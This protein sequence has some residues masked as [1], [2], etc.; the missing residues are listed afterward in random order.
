MLK[1]RELGLLT[2]ELET[3][4]LDPEIYRYQTKYGISVVYFMFDPELIRKF[5]FEP[6]Y[7]SPED[8][9]CEGMSEEEIFQAILES[10]VTIM[11][12]EIIPFSEY[13]REFEQFCE[14]KKK[15]PIIREIARA[16]ESVEDEKK[17]WCVTGAPRER[18]ASGALYHPLLRAFCETHG[19]AGLLIGFSDNDF[20]YLGE[21]NPQIASIMPSLVHELSH[22]VEGA[23]ELLDL[24]ILKYDYKTDTM[25]EFK[26]S[27]NYL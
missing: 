1:K 10:T 6:V 12:T 16:M 26:D 13:F 22:V 2:M 11:H 5:I 20:A 18:C 24:K 25:S 27:E 21:D 3:E 23:K 8:V 9:K 4:S 15:I 19:C 17:V 7:L 14:D